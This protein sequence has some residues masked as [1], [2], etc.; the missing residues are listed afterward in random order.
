MNHSTSNQSQSLALL[1]DLYQL[2]MAYSYW[3][4]G[5][6]DTEGVFHL[7][8]RKPPFQGGFTVAAG[9]DYLIDYVQNFE[10]DSSDLD[11]LA[12]LTGIDDEPLFEEG[13]LTYLKE[14]PFSCDIDAV[15]EGTAVFP[16]QPLV[17]VT[18]PIIQAQILESPLLNIIN[19]QTLIATKA[20][21]IVLAAQGDPV[22]EF[23]LRRAQGIDG[24]ISAS[25]AA[26][27]GGCES[28]SNVLAGKLFNIPVKGTVAHSWI[29]AFG[30]ELESFR[31]YAKAMPNNCVFLV[32]TYDTLDGVRKA[33]VVGKWLKEQ[34]QKMIGIRLDSGDLGYLSIESRKLLDAAGFEDAVIVAS[35]ELNETIIRELK[36]QG[37][38]I[39][40]WGVGTNLVTAY[41]QPALDGVYKLSAV[42]SHSKEDWRYTLKLS[43]QM[44][45]I[46]T[47][48]ILQI[49]RFYNEKENVGDAVFDTLQKQEG[50]WIIV[51]PLD[52]TRQRKVEPHLP[53]RDLLEPIFRNGECVYQ[54]P[55]LQTMRAR[56]QNE[57]NHFHQ[58]IKRFLN[59]HQYV[60]GLEQKT[61][62]MKAQLI[63]DI[64]EEQARNPINSEEIK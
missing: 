28:T 20:A 35:N 2:T 49:R 30:D 54:S 11:Y 64:R 10:F 37:A 9:L 59:P 19:F 8:F 41:D 16:Y 27:I 3:K 25:R 24:A 58:G 15:P 14:T 18:G 51:D 32:D 12:S 50:N 48:G 5:L 62:E 52:S 6:Q 43:E 42:R 60:V 21:R 1:T 7:H 47:P 44:I 4:L 61:Y 13:F 57:L 36:Q 56:A 31:A 22:L 63:R 17:R 46:S 33:I 29:M 40:V 53:Y 55:D 38:K 23:G 26:Y 39:S 45:K 34:G